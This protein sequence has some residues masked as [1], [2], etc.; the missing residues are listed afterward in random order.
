MFGRGSVVLACAALVLAGQ[1]G[2]GGAA[3]ASGCAGSGPPLRYVVLFDR[4]TSPAA[5]HREIE[6]ACGV[7]AAYYPEIAVGIAT[8]RDPR[9]A[10]LLG[11][12]RAFSAQAQRLVAQRS[13]AA[14]PGGL[15]PDT[16]DAA[17][18]P[19]GDRTAEQWNMRL[20]GADAARPVEPGGRGVVVGVLDS[21][22]DATHPEL[23]AAV[24]EALSAGCLSG[25]PDR[26]PRAWAPTGS[27]HG[28]HVAGVVAAADDG[29]GVSGVAPGVRLASVRVIDDDGFVDPEAAVCGLMWAARHRMDI[30]NSS[31]FVDPWTLSCAPK[32]GERVVHEAIA[33]AVEYADSVGTLTVAAAT[34]EAVNLT[35][36]PDG[37]G[38]DPSGRCEALPASLPETVTVSAVGPDL[39]KPGY[40]SYGLGVVDVTA[41]G[42]EGDRCVLS[43]VPGGYGEVCGTSM[44]APHVSGVAALLRSRDPEVSTD[45]LRTALGDQ[46]TPVACPADYDLTGDGTQDAYC[47]GYSGYNGFYGHGLV[48]ALAAVDGAEASPQEQPRQ[49]ARGGDHAQRGERE[50]VRRV[51]EHGQVRY[52][53]GQAPR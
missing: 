52:A 18:V 9:F 10:E 20:I 26:S 13:G 43:T 19:A 50:Q 44:A 12:D 14:A 4:G 35:P 33:R 6:S 16:T 41:P 48:N 28:T 22:V 45:D 15:R 34:N 42:G 39:R 25:A 29:S 7:P 23:A 38:L 8:A 2:H 32:D 51:P 17:A 46:A 3:A 47:A 49:A 5:A 1:L 31:F 53:Y 24:D 11:P 36:S 21:G 37:T 30:A 40:S 27:P